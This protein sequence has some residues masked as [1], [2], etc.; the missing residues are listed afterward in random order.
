MLGS[1]SSL[2]TDMEHALLIALLFIW[3]LLRG[4]C[5]G[6]AVGTAAGGYTAV[7]AP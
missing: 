6:G 7:P 5:V 4:G 1:V 2:L 3:I